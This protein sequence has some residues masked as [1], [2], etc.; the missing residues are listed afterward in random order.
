MGS[1]QKEAKVGVKITIGQARASGAVGL[2]LYCANYFETPGGCRHQSDM[3][4]LLAVALFGEDK[5]LD[6]LPFK[7]SVCGAREV[8]VRPWFESGTRKGR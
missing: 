7:C 6:D 3:T 4:M 1:L 5:R 8:N 2:L